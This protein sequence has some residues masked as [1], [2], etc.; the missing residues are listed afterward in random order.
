MSNF[1]PQRSLFEVREAPSKMYSWAVFLLCNIIVEMPFQIFLSVIVWAAFY[2]PVFGMHQTGTQ[3]GLMFAFTLQFLVFAATFAQML[4]FTLPSTEVAGSISTIM[5]TLTLQFNGVLQPPNALP[6]FWIF[7]YRVSPFTYLIGGWAGTGLADRP[8]ICAQNELAVFDPPQGQT[9]G[10]YLE[11][12]IQGGAPGTLLNP[13]AS[14]SCEYCP[15]R[16]ADQ[17]LAASWIYPSDRYRNLGIMFAYIG[18]NIAAGLALYYM[19]RVKRFSIK[20]LFPKK[21]AAKEDQ[22]DEPSEKSKEDKF[23]WGLSLLWAIIRNTV[24]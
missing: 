2:F 16:N 5:F 22:L 9:C 8:I 18:F 7:M 13:T 20:G 3:I 15:A 14:Q 12:Y 4:I 17:I 21:K 1:L 24:R 19:F 10:A 11:E 6:G 23:H